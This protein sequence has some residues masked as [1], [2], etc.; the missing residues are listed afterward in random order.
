MPMVPF[1]PQTVGQQRAG[2]GAS[3]PATPPPNDV[4]TLMAAAQMNSE[5]RLFKAPTGGVNDKLDSIS[6]A[7]AAPLRR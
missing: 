6:P 1:R 5:G 7:D 2:A 3:A 4:Y